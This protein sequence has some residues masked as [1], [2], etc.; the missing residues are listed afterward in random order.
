[1]EI[2]E[3][4]LAVSN[5]GVAEL[6]GV[7]LCLIDRVKPGRQ[8]ERAEEEADGGC[9]GENE[10]FTS[11]DE[12]YVVVYRRGKATLAE[13]FDVHICN[14]LRHILVE[15]LTKKN[16]SADPDCCGPKMESKVLCDPRFGTVR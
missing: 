14:E 7:R 12:R 2:L 6:L 11:C 15:A 5:L 13:C 10:T 3:K 4:Y 16:V 9:C 1:M 8:T